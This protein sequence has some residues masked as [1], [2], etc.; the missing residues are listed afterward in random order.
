MTEQR[1]YI[2]TGAGGG[3]GGATAER[4]LRAGGNVLGVDVSQRRLDALGERAQDLPGEYATHRA[5]LTVDGGGQAV[6]DAAIDRF[7]VIHGLAN[8]AG[9]MPN[10]DLGGFDIAIEDLPL[11]YF[12]ATFA[13]NVDSAFL[14]AKAIAPHFYEHGYGKIVNTASLAAFSNYHELGNL[15]YNAAKAAV[16]GLSQAM[17]MLMGDKGVRVNCIAPG[18]VMSPKVL[19][20]VDAGY[21]ARHKANAAMPD[22]ASPENLADGMAF[23]LEPGSDAVSGEVLRVAAGVR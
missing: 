12:R 3:I 18:L 9:G 23:F 1:S 7:E 14:T 13:L 11:D 8:I 21:V 10:I 16:V 20:F 15:A 22:L 17:S 6:A 4:L 2:V 5:D 19:E